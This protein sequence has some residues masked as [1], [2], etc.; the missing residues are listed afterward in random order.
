M[1][2][3]GNIKGVKESL[4]LILSKM[5]NLCFIFPSR[6]VFDKKK[7]IKRTW[8]GREDKVEEKEWVVW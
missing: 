5:M 7:V 6:F 4:C 1:R 3:K 8:K 2:R